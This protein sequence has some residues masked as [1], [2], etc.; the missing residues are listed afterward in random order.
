MKFNLI[1]YFLCKNGLT[2]L[3]C[4]YDLRRVYLMPNLDNGKNAL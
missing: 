2:S 1:K 3:T 4:Q